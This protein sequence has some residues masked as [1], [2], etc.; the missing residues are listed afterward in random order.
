MRLLHHMFLEIAMKERCGCMRSFRRFS[1]AAWCFGSCRSAAQPT[2]KYSVAASDAGRNPVGGA[3]PLTAK[4]SSRQSNSIQSWKG[5][6]SHSLFLKSLPR[7]ICPLSIGLPGRIN[8]SCTLWGRHLS[9]FRETLFYLLMLCVPA[10]LDLYCLWT[11]F[12]KIIHIIFYD[13]YNI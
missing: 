5:V 7:S 13:M 3:P 2:K 9:Y 4:R 12:I 1:R 10:R 8:S 11:G 6:R